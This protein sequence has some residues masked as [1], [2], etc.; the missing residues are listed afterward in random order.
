M[1]GFFKKHRYGIII[2]SAIVLTLTAVFF[3]ADGPEIKNNTPSATGSVSY[4]SGVVVE[5]KNSSEPN[6]KRSDKALSESPEHSYE[7]TVESVNETTSSEVSEIK[8]EDISSEP[9]P[10]ISD[11]EASVLIEESSSSV[12]EQSI[13]QGREESSEEISEASPEESEAE[14][15]HKCTISISCSVLNDHIDE[16]AKNKRQLV[17]SDGMILSPVEAEFSEGESVF[18]VTK[19]ICI[20]NRIHFEFTMTPLYNTAYIEGIYNLYEFDCGSASGWVYSVNRE[21]PSFGCSDYKVHDGDV[22]VW[23]YTCALGNDVEL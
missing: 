17:P 13:V 3:L 10:E 23:H 1:S 2:I 4:A 8:T 20:E 16:L 22:I 9:A 7:S 15:K 14:K 11:S 18:D 12:Q 5:P 19:R 6:E 21:L